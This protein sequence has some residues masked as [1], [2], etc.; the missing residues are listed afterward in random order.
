MTATSTDNGLGLEDKQSSTDVV[1]V[2]SS[3]DVVPV[4]APARRT[5]S[6]PLTAP[7]A[8]AGLIAEAEAAVRD[9]RWRDALRV[10]DAVN[11]ID[12]SSVRTDG[13]LAVAATHLSKTRLAAEAV[14]RIR[15]AA[16]TLETHRSLAA[17][18]LA[19]HE[20]LTADAEVR[21]ALELA[22][23]DEAAHDWVNLA[24]SYAGLGW[25]GEAADCLDRA[26]Q[27]GIEEPDTWIIGR[28]TNH[29]SMSKTW[30]LAVSIGLFFFVGLLA[31]AIGITV[32]FMVREFRLTQLGD[33]FS[34]LATDA[35]SKERWLR[36]AHAAAVLTTVVAWSFIVQIS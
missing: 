7:V 26:E 35:W 24:A 27:L 29:W 19:R 2:A 10:L 5:S 6:I 22:D 16:P 15:A 21:A 13:L 11:A 36:L 31:V 33:R 28:S 12:A 1:P 8:G 18:A 14:G 23:E 9:H 3:T 30:A 17:V 20:Y 34:T 32:P 4:H 25:F